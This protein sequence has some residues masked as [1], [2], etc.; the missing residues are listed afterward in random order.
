[1][2]REGSR[3]GRFQV[4]TMKRTAKLAK[5]TTWVFGLNVAFGVMLGLFSLV[6]GWAISHCSAG[7]EVCLYD[8]YWVL[9]NV[10]Y[11]LVA[12][13]VLCRIV[14][15]KVEQRRVNLGSDSWYQRALKS[16]SFWMSIGLLLVANFYNTAYVMDG[17]RSREF[18]LRY[19]VSSNCQIL[20][21]LLLGRGLFEVLWMCRRR[22]WHS[23]DQRLAYI[24][25]VSKTWCRGLFLFVVLGLV[26]VGLISWGNFGYF[27]D[28]LIVR[29]LCTG[30]LIFV[31][32]VGALFSAYGR[33]LGK[34]L[35]NAKV[36]AANNEY[37]RLINGAE[38]GDGGLTSSEASPSS[39]EDGEV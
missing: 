18:L 36:R 6:E 32:S 14:E 25:C 37:D 31:G 4:G 8:N 1:M 12:T 5:L 19:V 39:N 38:H 34:N 21:V 13:V 11:S 28:E 9:R 24:L 23:E 30:F 10:I 27:V 33:T 16:T 7:Q 22:N 29:L 15:R 26:C 20:S 35:A 2:S 17:D 3:I